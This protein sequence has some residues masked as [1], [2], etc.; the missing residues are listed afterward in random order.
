[1]SAALSRRS[2]L[3]AAIFGLATHLATLPISLSLAHAQGT[4]PVQNPITGKE[5]LGDLSHPQ[6][7][8]AQFYRRSILAICR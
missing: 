3:P 2:L 5:D 8:L 4:K 6:Q 7:A 1:M